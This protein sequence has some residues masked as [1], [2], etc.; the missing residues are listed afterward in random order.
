L[1][2]TSTSAQAAT[3]TDASGTFNNSTACFN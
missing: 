2:T 3:V 1:L